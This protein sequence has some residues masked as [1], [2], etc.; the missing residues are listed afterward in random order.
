MEEIKNRLNELLN[1]ISN[2]PEY[3]GETFSYS[4]IYFEI[5]DSEIYEMPNDFSY[6]P[7]G[8]S[9]LDTF[10]GPSKEENDYMEWLMKE[11]DFNEYFF[12]ELIEDY[13]YFSE[14]NA[15]EYFELEYLEDMEW[16]VDEDEKD[17][18]DKARTYLAIV[19]HIEEDDSPFDDIQNFS[20][21]LEYYG[22]ESDRLYYEFEGEICDFLETCSVAMEPRGTFEDF[23]DEKWIEILENISEYIE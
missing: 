17:M 11:L 21:T 23:T 15:Q 16:D 14:E 5:C 7:R 12:Q 22:L 2:N 10:Y 13:G 4:G 19:K 9:G 3:Q 8:G 1:Q 6:S 20:E 18:L